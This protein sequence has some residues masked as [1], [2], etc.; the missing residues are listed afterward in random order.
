M[1]RIV[2]GVTLTL[3]TAVPLSTDGRTFGGSD[4]SQTPAIAT[5]VGTAARFH[6]LLGRGD[7]AGA[8][9]LLAPDA[10]VLESGDVETRSQY[11]AHHLGEDIEFART[12]P[13]TRTIVG[14]RRDG[15]AVWITATSVSKG[16]FGDRQIDSRGAELMIL[17]RSGSKWLIRAIHWSSH[18]A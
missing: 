13:S 15:N 7:S 10:I 11:V 1:I 5:A 16:K 9:R 14:S 3:L 6:E 4:A 12:V 2:S 18:K 8:E 17:T